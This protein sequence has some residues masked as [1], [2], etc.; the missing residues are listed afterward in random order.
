MTVAVTSLMSASCPHRID[1]SIRDAINL[2]LIPGPRMWAA[3][4]ELCC[5][6]DVIDAQN[7]FWHYELGTAGSTRKVDGPDGFRQVVREEI[8]WGAD[9]VKVNVSGG[10]G[11]PSPALP[12]SPR[13][14]N[15]PAARHPALPA[16]Q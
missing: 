3:S 10:H 1:P 11:V 8:A 13:Q 5:S 6:G 4:H 2:G 16:E 12:L 9:V 14:R 7:L 15:G